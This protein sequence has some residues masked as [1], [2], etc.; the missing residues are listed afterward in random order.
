MR[1]NEDRDRDSSK[2]DPVES[3]RKIPTVSVEWLENAAADLEVSANASRETWALLGLSHRYSENIG[4]AHAM[5]HA[6]RMK[7]DYD[8]R[9]FLRTV[10]LKV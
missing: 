3:K 2:G 10:G 7:L 9:L 6:A 4:R 1:G 8:R 5:R